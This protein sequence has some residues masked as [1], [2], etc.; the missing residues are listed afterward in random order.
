VS[1]H[2]I[3]LSTLGEMSPYAVSLLYDWRHHV[4]CGAERLPATRSR[5]RAG[6]IREDLW[7]EVIGIWQTRKPVLQSLGVPL[8]SSGVR[9]GRSER[10]VYVLCVL[11][12]SLNDATGS[13]LVPGTLPPTRRP[14]LDRV[15]VLVRQTANSSGLRSA[16][17]WP[18][19]VPKLDRALVAG[20]LIAAGP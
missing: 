15:R 3:L 4:K 10:P 1:A 5:Q 7:S 8:R 2:G 20:V 11:P 18:C 17:P 19:G 13:D 14:C 16:T 12:S 9:R 6:G